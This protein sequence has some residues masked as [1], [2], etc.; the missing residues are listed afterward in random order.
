MPREPRKEPFEQLYQRLE[1]RVARLEQ[2]GLSLDESIAVYEEGMTLARQ[3]Q[4]LLDHAELKVLKLK[5]SFAPLAPR[6]G[7]ALEQA[8]DE[9]YEYVT[10]DEAPA[11]DDPFA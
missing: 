7:T 6:N 8:P 1:E 2:G 9:T 5:E 10:D 11:E 4:E 3:C